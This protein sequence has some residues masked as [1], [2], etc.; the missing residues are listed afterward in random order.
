MVAKLQSAFDSPD[1]SP[2]YLLMIELFLERREHIDS[3]MYIL[4]NSDM[5]HLAA[6]IYTASTS[7]ATN[8]EIMT[9]LDY[10]LKRTGVKRANVYPTHLISTLRLHDRGINNEALKIDEKLYGL[11]NERFQTNH[12]PYSSVREKLR[13]AFDR[14]DA[15]ASVPYRFPET[16]MTASEKLQGRVYG[17]LFG[18]NDRESGPG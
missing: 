3:G 14:L 16:A 10:M 4:D 8:D 12:N 17:I 7:G 15:R 9:S 1:N 18:S 13:L 5:S 11:I 2:N 6:L